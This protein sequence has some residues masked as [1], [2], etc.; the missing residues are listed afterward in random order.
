MATIV[1]SM[2]RK[3]TRM[4]FKDILDAFNEGTRSVVSVAVACVVV[5]IIIGVVSLTGFGLNMA[6]AIIQL[7]QANLLLTLIVTMVTCMILG[8]RLPSTMAAPALVKLW[9]PPLAAHMFVFYFAM[10]ANITPP[11]ALASFAAVGI[12]GGDPMKTGLQSVKL[13][14]AGFIV[15]YMFIY[16]TAL[17]L[18]DTTPRIALRVTAMAIVG[19][20]MIGMATEGYM[21]RKMNNL[22]RVF[23]LCGALL[24]ITA[25]IYQDVVGLILLSIVLITQRIQ[26]KKDGEKQEKQ[27]VAE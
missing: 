9:I 23:S 4:S 17:L 10:F 16:N 6:N 22:L 21:I 18:I 3:S 1:I 5:G 26:Y 25:N 19:V 27:I 2:T 15:P 24:L 14:L 20:C 7:G 13:S 8:M 12:S 11:V